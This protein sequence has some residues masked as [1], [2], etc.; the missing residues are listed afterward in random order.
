MI[1]AR[2]SIALRPALSL[3][4]SRAQLVVFVPGPRQ[5]ATVI[6]TRLARHGWTA[7]ETSGAS[8]SQSSREPAWSLVPGGGLVGENGRINDCPADI[9]TVP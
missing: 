7:F 6:Q 8:L 5:V 9:L 4:Q 3:L 2:P 1:G